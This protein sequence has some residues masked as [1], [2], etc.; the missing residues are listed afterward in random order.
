MSQS[1]LFNYEDSGDTKILVATCMNSVWSKTP[2]SE[3][4][5]LNRAFECRL[6]LLRI[7]VKVG[8]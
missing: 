2:Q 1:S 5:E 4:H 3:Q 7:A 6:F 8:S